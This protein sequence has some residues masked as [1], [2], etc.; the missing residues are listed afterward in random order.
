M[1][2]KVTRDTLETKTTVILDDGPRDPRAKER[3]NTPLIFFNHMLEHIAWRSELNITVELEMDHF[4]LNHLVCEDVGITMGR[5]FKELLE[6]RIPAGGKGYGFALATIDESLARAV[7][8]FESRTYFDFTHDD[9]LIPGT[10]EG[11]HSED[12]IAFWE[13]FTVGAQATVHLDLLKARDNHGHHQWE[14]L[15]RAAGQALKDALSIEPW[16]RDMA[17]GVAGKISFEVEIE[18]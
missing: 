3:I 15:F 18:E 9:I 1:K 17:S 11:I 8:S 6:K 14:S 16:R 7:V 2:I 4:F 13:G 5:A 10:T 12:L